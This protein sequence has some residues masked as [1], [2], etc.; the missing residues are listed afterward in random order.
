LGK[1]LKR[2]PKKFGHIPLG[3][4]LTTSPSSSPTLVFSFFPILIVEENVF[5]PFVLFWDV[6]LSFSKPKKEREKEKHSKKERKKDKHS[7]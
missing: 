3:F 5:P 1:E 2:I 6:F 7:P 4:F